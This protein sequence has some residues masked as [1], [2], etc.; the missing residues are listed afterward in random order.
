MLDSSSSREASRPR[1]TRRREEEAPRATPPGAR[2]RSPPEAES[3]PLES[4][5][6]ECPT[7]PAS[8]DDSHKVYPASES[9]DGEQIEENAS[10]ATVPY[11][12]TALNRPREDLP[13]DCNWG[14]PQHGGDGDDAFLFDPARDKP[15]LNRVRIW[16]PEASA[17]LNGVIGKIVQWYAASELPF[18]AN[19]GRWEVRLENGARAL[20][21]RS[22]LVFMH[23]SGPLAPRSRPA[24]G[25][26]RAPA[27]R[28]ILGLENWNCARALL[29]RS[30]FV[31]M[32]RSGPL[33]PLSR[34]AS[35]GRR[36]PA[37][38]CILVPGPRG[39][40]HPSLP[41]SGGNRVPARKCCLKPRPQWITELPPGAGPRPA[42]LA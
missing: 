13:R 21:K 4:C 8:G 16:G 36:A 14:G 17:H 37:R 6:G 33:A 2:K 15:H 18:V 30:N 11:T 23:R 7:S 34:P 35:G 28:C 40:S 10:D 12:G 26:R 20:L 19:E 5:D 25:G 9:S 42:W 38:R 24:S 31:F 3:S 22:N 27:R 41:A 32:H 1:R 39:R 29:K